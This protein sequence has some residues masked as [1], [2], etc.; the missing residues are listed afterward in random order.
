MSKT[1]QRLLFWSPRILC[2]AFAVFISLFA[3]DVFDEHLGVWQTVQALAIHLVPAIL[4]V[5]VLAL[6]WRWEWVGA[7][8][9]TAMGAL[10]AIRM[11]HYPRVVMGISGPLFLVAALFLVNWFK[12][13]ELHGKVE[14]AA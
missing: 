13:A 4:V 10:Y 6:A 8:L 2:L 1:A 11:H 5:L 14:H 7:A 9:F 12:H 3:L